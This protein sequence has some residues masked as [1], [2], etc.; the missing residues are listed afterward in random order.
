M[1]CFEARIRL[2]R[3]LQAADKESRVDQENERERNLR[4]HQAAQETTL[5]QSK[6]DAGRFLLENRLH[7]Q[8][9]RS[10]GRNNTKDDR[11]EDGSRNRREKHV[12]I[13]VRLGSQRKIAGRKERDE[14]VGGP[15]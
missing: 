15:S 9:R 1:T 2:L 12:L 7:R 4:H 3:F 14:A 8:A 6:R 5:V 13:D 11:G 10:Q